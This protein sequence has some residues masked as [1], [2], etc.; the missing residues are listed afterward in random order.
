MRLLK[1][2]GGKRSMVGYYLG[3]KSNHTKADAQICVFF[4]T[5]KE[6]H[7]KAQGS[8]AQRANPGYTPK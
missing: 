4:S 8:R 2:L 1:K 6:L 5:P 7:S 3:N